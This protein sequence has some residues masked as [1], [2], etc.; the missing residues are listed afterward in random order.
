[1]HCEK[2]GGSDPD[3]VWHH[4]SDRSRDEAGSAVWRSFHGKGTFGGEFAARHCNQCVLYGVRVRQ[5]RDTALF[6]NYF[7]HTC[8][9]LIS[10][11][12]QYL[13]NKDARTASGDVH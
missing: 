7:G 1:M 6:P 2:N 10:I 12:H 8:F 9:I 11:Y 5:C 13:L 3:A 4:R